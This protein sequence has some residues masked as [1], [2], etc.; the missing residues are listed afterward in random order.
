MEVVIPALEICCFNYCC[1][2]KKKTKNKMDL[3]KY[4]LFKA[5]E[6]EL[7]NKLNFINLMKVIDQF[8]LMSKIFLN[9]SQCF[10][11]QN[12]DLQLI[13]DVKRYTEDYDSIVDEKMKKKKEK[14]TKYL[15][16]KLKEKSL[17]TVDKLL[18]KYLKKDFID[19]L[20][21]EFHLN[22]E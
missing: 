3:H 18:F 5:A 4:E 17:T 8:R 6:F 2:D 22:L 20:Q 11:L 10:M 21:N 16:E 13:R 14:L 9:E 19:E 15:A 12:R 7:E 1:F